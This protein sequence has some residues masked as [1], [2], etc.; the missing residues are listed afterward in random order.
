[1]KKLPFLLSY[2]LL[3]ILNLSSTAQT[4]DS[5]YIDQLK[6]RHIG[7]VG[8]RL[9]SVAGIPGDVLTYY[10]GAA[11][12]GIWKTVDG[13]LTWK[14][15][16]DKQP[17][18]SIGA[19]AVAASDPEIIY[20]GTGEAFIRS[21]I[22]IGNGVWKSTDG[23][24]HWS[25]IGLEN[26]GRI[27]RVVVDPNNPDIVYVAALGHAYTPQKER[28]IF[29]SMDGG[30]TWN[31]VLKVD[32]N[33]GASD[34][35]MDPYNPRILFAGMW[36]L[37]I[38]PWTRTSGG[39]GSG[40]YRSL[41]AGETWEK[42][43][44]NGLPKGDIGKIALAMTPAQPQR[45]Y[46]LIETG[47]GIPLHGKPTNTGELWRSDDRGKTFTLVNSNRDLTGRGAYYT[48]CAASPDNPNEIY[49]IAASY[50][51]SIDGGQT[52]TGNPPGSDP[53]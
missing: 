8:N 30:K 24:D 29:K 48:R 16:F 31:H 38:R 3:F 46:A 50:F 11:A 6:F 20:A 40:I 53:N 32:E 49:F 33:T 35:V 17:V 23:G 25:H 14:P 15:L 41:D 39:P 47:D 28:G 37:E 52:T 36:Q 44:K 27:S 21:N 42:M 7:P 9:I 12:G 10:V 1:M 22:S 19:L 5:G 18:H 26:T 51:T 43:E 45:I 2:I 13:G 4:L 34:L